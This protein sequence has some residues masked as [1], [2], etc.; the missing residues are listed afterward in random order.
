MS[1]NNIDE[2]FI[3][4]YDEPDDSLQ[5]IIDTFMAYNHDAPVIVALVSLA[6][7]QV[8]QV[9][10]VSEADSSRILFVGS[11]DE[12]VAFA[13]DCPEARILPTR[14][15]LRL[16]GAL[17]QDSCV[18]FCKALIQI[19][20]E[21]SDQLLSDINDSDIGVW[22]DPNEWPMYGEC[23]RSKDLERI[24]LNLFGRICPNKA[25]SHYFNRLISCFVEGDSYIVFA[26]H[27]FY[28][29]YEDIEEQFHVGLYPHDIYEYWDEKIWAMDVFNPRYVIDLDL[30][31]VQQCR[32]LDQWF[33]NPE[34][35]MTILCQVPYNRYLVYPVIEKL[36]EAKFRKALLLVNAGFLSDFDPNTYNA[37]GLLTSSGKISWVMSLPGVADDNY[38]LICLE[39]KNCEQV[40]FVDGYSR[41]KLANFSNGNIEDNLK[42]FE[43]TCIE[44][45]ENQQVDSL[46]V[47]VGIGEVQ[48]AT[49]LN[50][51][52]F[53]NPLPEFE[54][55]GEFDYIELGQFL[56]VEPMAPDECLRFLE[57][58]RP[59]LTPSGFPQNEFGKVRFNASI[60]PD[61]S[62][63][64]KFMEGRRNVIY[65]SRESG[66]D[67]FAIVEQS[68]SFAVDFSCRPLTV[69]SRSI[70]IHY[71]LHQLYRK[72]IY[73]QV[74]LKGKYE[75]DNFEK[76]FEKILIPVPKGPDSLS[77]Q[78]QIY[79][80]AKKVYLSHNDD[81]LSYD[82]RQDSIT[83]SDKVSDISLDCEN[84]TISFLDYNHTIELESQH[85]AIYLFLL[86][87]TADSKAIKDKTSLTDYKY[88]LAKI[89]Y[90]IKSKANR[91]SETPQSTAFSKVF[92]SMDNI[93]CQ[94]SQKV[95]KINRQLKEE[96]QPLTSQASTYCIPSG[97]GV[98]RR[99]RIDAGKHI[100]VSR[101]FPAN[102]LDKPMRTDEY[103]HE[104]ILAMTERAKSKETTT[105][106]EPPEVRSYRIFMQ[107]REALYNQL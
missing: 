21:D 7:E 106:K 49:T 94:F 6:F 68:E 39:A 92:D 61:N 57:G 93:L 78:Q 98:N 26:S 44:M 2:D 107:E 90:A 56:E 73:L 42:E 67:Q 81:P 60:N 58:K 96:L 86:R 101:G 8:L 20:K 14:T 97:Q 85:F 50:P 19:I 11:K 12:C 27:S 17:N 31:P 72:E 74:P 1:S 63:G 91:Y 89:Y 22:W 25:P 100:V 76:R 66:K 69:Y 104:T 102:F 34:G 62:F 10:D 64:Y 65:Y 45:I 47:Q 37:R 30:R 23:V 99:I 87:P 28:R 15:L 52:F 16:S 36:L 13:P 32:D 33:S 75:L 53:V 4:P 88:E 70:D 103:Y 84:C 54:G 105:H 43:D 51:A 29:D 35:Y 59:L 71:L 46:S 48:S 77:R 9:T 79:E 40:T 95:S 18:A 3:P 80:T 5:E 24:Y 83:K 38:A 82:I 55:D 41:Y